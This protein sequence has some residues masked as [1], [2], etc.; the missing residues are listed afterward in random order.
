MTYIYL[1]PNIL[2]YNDY[3]LPIYRRHGGLRA[4]GWASKYC[5][6]H[7]SALFYK[8]IIIIC[9]QNICIY[10]NEL[11]TFTFPL[12]PCIQHSYELAMYDQ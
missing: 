7:L 10:I 3:E 8:C 12:L 2:L 11:K 9:Q 1:V 4:E 6:V 5:D